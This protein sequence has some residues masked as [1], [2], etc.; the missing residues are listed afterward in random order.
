MGKVHSFLSEMKFTF[1][2]SENTRADL[3][4]DLL[5]R[6]RELNLEEIRFI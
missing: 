4:S 6:A 5:E 3:H 1:I 2:I